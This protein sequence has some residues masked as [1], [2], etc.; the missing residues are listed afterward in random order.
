M[1]SNENYFIRLAR[2]RNGKIPMQPDV[3]NDT[4]FSMTVIVERG[5]DI[6]R[7]GVPMLKAVVESPAFNEEEY[8]REHR[9]SFCRSADKRYVDMGRM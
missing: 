4:H 8:I 6:A 5:E 2:D 7:F 1:V 3:G 9:E